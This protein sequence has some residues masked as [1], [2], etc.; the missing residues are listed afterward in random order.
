MK[1][2]SAQRRYGFASGCQFVSSMVG[3]ALIA[4]AF[5]STHGFTRRSQF[6]ITLTDWSPVSAAG[7]TNR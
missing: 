6:R 3:A 4:P 7:I 2:S 5:V 1:D